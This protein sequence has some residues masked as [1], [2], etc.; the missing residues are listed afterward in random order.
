MEAKSYDYL[1]KVVI[2]GDLGVGKTSI[3]KKYTHDEYTNDTKGTIGIDF[4][5]RYEDYAGKIVKIQIWDTAGQERFKS[6]IPT[7]LRNSNILL[8]VCN[9]T[10]ARNWGNIPIWYDGMK[11][12]IQND[13]VVIGVLINKIDK[14]NEKTYKDIKKK[15]EKYLEKIPYDLLI[16]TSA[17]TGNNIKKCFNL[18][19]SK[20]VGL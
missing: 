14:V 13:L 5:D 8:I 15:M 3:A 6:M 2:V 17:K 11:D 4:F 16:L 10:K 7:V 19:G 1:C 20:F 12:Y 18:L 9:A